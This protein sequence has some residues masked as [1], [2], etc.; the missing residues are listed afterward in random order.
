MNFLDRIRFIALS[1]FGSTLLKKQE[2]SM[3][4]RM[5]KAISSSSNSAPQLVIL[6]KRLVEI[7]TEQHHPVSKQ[8]RLLWE[9]FKTRGLTRMLI[10]LFPSSA[11]LTFTSA[12]EMSRDEL[13]KYLWRNRKLLRRKILFNLS[14]EFLPDIK[15]KDYDFLT[16]VDYLSINFEA[17]KA[18]KSL[19]GFETRGQSITKVRIL[20]KVKKSEFKD[21][22]H[23]I[24]V[25]NPQ[26]FIRLVYQ[27]DLLNHFQSYLSINF[28][29]IWSEISSKKMVSLDVHLHANI[30]LDVRLDNSAQSHFEMLEKVEIWHQRFLVKDAK[31]KI[32]DS[33]TD[34]RMKFVAGQWQ[35]VER[36]PGMNDEVLIR[37]PRSTSGNI[38]KA[39]FL[40]GRCDENWYHFLIDTLPRL[41]AI[42]GIPLGVPLLIRSDIPST[43]KDLIRRLVTRRII[44][45]DPDSVLK[46]DFLY[47]VPSRSSVFD[48]EVPVNTEL[49]HLPIATL[50]KLRDRVIEGQDL[51]SRFSGPDTFY[52]NRGA[53]LRRIL[54]TSS[55]ETV[56]RVLGVD[57]LE[58]NSNFF[59]YQVS[60]FHQANLVIIPGGASVTNILFMKPGTK[61]L[62]LKSWRNRKLNLWK[63]LALGLG[64]EYKEINGV[65]NYYG[66]NYLRRMHSDY[67][68][69]PRKLKRELSNFITSRT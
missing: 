18:L 19:W 6:T 10:T 64:L 39:I 48:S 4:Q 2:E 68:I 23:N 32:I 66:L 60:A 47:F 62:I 55:V 29:S 53:A 8:I 20:S 34:P 7:D 51:A 5:L 13:L 65:P 37:K 35:F 9:I 3:V 11:Q 14:L 49:L 44:E 31:W 1:C 42:Q 28:P 59:K 36:I 56:M 61:V 24:I 33:T 21:V 16:S 67:W 58:S 63:S 52:L 22:I 12:R 69:P 57:K 27:Y 30:C 43:S 54:N 26:Y 41:E 15:I 50:R 25:L 38:P 17:N 40:C 45:I 46:V